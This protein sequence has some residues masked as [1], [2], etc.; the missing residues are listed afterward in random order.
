[1]RLKNIY[2]ARFYLCK[3]LENANLVTANEWL[4]ENRE[5]GGKDG[6]QS[7]RRKLVGNG[8]VYFYCDVS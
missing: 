3:I 2:M 7:S 4:S 6:L 8:Y 1:M 5:M